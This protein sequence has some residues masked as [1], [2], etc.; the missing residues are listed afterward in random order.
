MNQ[1]GNTFSVIALVAGI[2]S[3]II[4]PLFFGLIAVITAMIAIGINS[5]NNLSQTKAIWGLVLGIVGLLWWFFTL[6]L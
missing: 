4:F 6:Y 2:V 1:P 5:S 3:L